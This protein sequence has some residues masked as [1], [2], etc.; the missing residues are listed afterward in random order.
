MASAKRDRS[1]D[2]N[3][4]LAALSPEAR[5]RLEPRLEPVE[6]AVRE[7]LCVPDEPIMHVWF[8]DTG[9]VS[10][11]SVLD[12]ERYVEVATIGHEGLVGIPVFLGAATAPTHA[13]VQI[14]VTARRMKAHVFREEV[15]RTGELRSVVQRYAQALFN[16]IAQT[17]GCNRGHAVEQRCARWLLQTHDRVDRAKTFALTHEFLAQM[18]GV[19]RATV[20]EVAGA[21]QDAGI[22]EYTRGSVTILDRK[23]LEA[24]SCTCYGLIRDEFEKLVG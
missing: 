22:I 24:I 18:L 3:R 1:A 4:M 8:V 12:G 10:L 6:L 14:A 13:F 23:K 2:G 19:R 9:I 16:Q 20:T 11:V 15:D 7:S 21:L 5:A 17:A